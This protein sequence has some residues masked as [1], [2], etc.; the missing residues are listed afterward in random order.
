[1]YATKYDEEITEPD[2]FFDEKALEEEEEEE[3]SSFLPSKEK[4]YTAKEIFK[5]LEL[6]LTFIHNGRELNFI[7]LRLR[8]A[9]FREIAR[10]THCS[11][12]IVNRFFLR[13]KRISPEAGVFLDYANGASD[14]PFQEE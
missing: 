8:G 1:M 14:S 5:A 9:S 3:T 12:T 7:R 10:K 11:H 2:I 6:L 13:V 4:F